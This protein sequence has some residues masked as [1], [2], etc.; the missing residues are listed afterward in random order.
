MQSILIVTVGGSPAPI[1]TSIRDLRPDRVAFLCSRQ[2][3]DT[4]LRSDDYKPIRDLPGV[5]LEDGWIVQV[6][7]ED[8]IDNCFET[9]NALI[10]R[11]KREFP[12]VELKLD[13]TGGTK[14]MAAGAAIAALRHGLPLFVTTALRENIKAVQAGEAASLAGMPRLMALEALSGE[15]PRLF[16]AGEYRA[17]AE[18]VRGMLRTV[19]DSDLLDRL[20]QTRRFCEGLDAWDRFQYAEALEALRGFMKLDS[21]R[22]LVLNLKAVLGSLGALPGGEVHPEGIKGSGYEIVL[23]VL[24]N[25][26]R[27]ARAGRFDDAV[28][29]LYRATELLEQVRLWQAYE[30]DTS[31]CPVD[32]L[33]PS[34]AESFKGQSEAKLGCQN[35]FELLASMEDDPVGRVYAGHRNHVKDALL[36]R[37]ESFLA[38]G[39]TP[40][41]R[42][43]YEQVLSRLEA[44]ILEA[45]REATG[46]EPSLQEWPV[47]LESLGF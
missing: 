10:E 37:N 13:Y 34:L 46:K 25:A 40:I 17:L 4:L 41:S 19:T 47:D 39:V 21:V 15:L 11:L 29:R 23:D 5:C 36:A 3:R 45:V 18:T 44:F 30:I 2:T 33:P 6:T 42:E 20:Q 16:A 8:R 32:K 9:A 12:G 43:R 35:G 1:A 22:P 14:S 27:R 7:H 38:H 26:K 31:R 28:S 24:A